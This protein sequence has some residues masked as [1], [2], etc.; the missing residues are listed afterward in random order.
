[1]TRRRLPLAAALLAACLLLAK[2]AAP[3]VHSELETFPYP[4][5]SRPFYYSGSREFGWP[6][7]FRAEFFHVPNASLDKRLSLYEHLSGGGR[8]KVD[9]NGSVWSSM[10]LIADF[11]FAVAA[12]T[13]IALV[14]TAVSHRRYSM[15]AFMG[16]TTCVIL[17]IGWIVYA[18]MLPPPLGVPRFGAG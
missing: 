15:K 16:F 13:L 3:F 8:L 6:A 7:P 2:N 11:T 10:A 18:Q 1:M 9:E 14:G 4:G 17:L 12:L 5:N